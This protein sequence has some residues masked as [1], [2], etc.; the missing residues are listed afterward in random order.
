MIMADGATHSILDVIPRVNPVTPSCLQIDLAASHAPVYCVL[1]FTLLFPCTCNRVLIT[2]CKGGEKKDPNS[3]DK[4]GTNKIC[5]KIFFLLPVQ[6]LKAF[7]NFSEDYR[8]YYEDTRIHNCK[9]QNVVERAMLPNCKI[10]IQ[11]VQN[12]LYIGW[13]LNGIEC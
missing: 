13:G 5:Q 7:V 6:D 1:L 12:L 8:E 3:F 11:S 2:S 4:I 9:I 10:P